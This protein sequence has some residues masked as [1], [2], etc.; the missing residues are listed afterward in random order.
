[1][2][3]VLAWP[4]HRSPSIL[5]IPGISSVSYL[6]ESL[7]ASDLNLP[8]DAMMAL[9]ALWQASVPPDGARRFWSGLL[10]AWQMR[11]TMPVSPL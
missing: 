9:M 1:M 11:Q 6:R 7:A 10:R 3:V 4:L 5:L 8:H 2:R